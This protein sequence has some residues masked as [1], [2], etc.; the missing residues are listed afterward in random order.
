MSCSFEKRCPVLGCA[1]V[2]HC[3]NE[4]R[5]AGIYRHFGAD[6]PEVTMMSLSAFT[7]VEQLM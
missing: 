4:V 7:S 5:T 6:V 3:E 2:G 1:C